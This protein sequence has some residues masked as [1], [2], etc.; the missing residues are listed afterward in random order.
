MSAGR[1]RSERGSALLITVLTSAALTALG[2]GYLLLA[3]TEQLISTSGRNTEQLL[4][5]AEAGARMIKTWFDNPVT[6]NPSIS[7]QVMHRFLGTY[8]LRNPAFYDR[9]RRIFDH[10]GDPNTAPVTAD[11][12]ASRPFYRQGRTLWA[13]SPYLD[14]FHKPYRGDAATTFL[15]SATGPD[16]ILEDRPNVIDLLD[17]L[18]NALF[19]DQERSGRISRI[20]I[21]AP[22]TMSFSGQPRSTGFATVEVTA[23]KFRR[24]GK[25]GIVPLVMNHSQKVAEATVKIVLG[26]VPGTLADGP[27]VSCGNISVGG[28]LHARWGRVIATGDVTLPAGLDAAVGSAFP[29]DGSDRRIHGN[30]PGD[31]YYDWINDPN[32]VVEDPWVT[33]EAAGDLTGY[34]GLPAQP[35][36]YDQ[37]APIDTDHSNLFQGSPSAT[38]PEIGYQ[39]LRAAA[40]SGEEHARYFEWDAST[41]LFKE[42]GRGA[43][44]TVRDWTHNQEGL[45]FFDTRDALPP[46]GH[47]PG[48]PQTNLTP[49][50]VIE[51]TDWAFSGLLYLNA[52]LFRMR[53]GSGA[54][55]VIIPPGEPYDDADG[56]GLHDPGEDYV[57]LL[58]PTTVIQGNPGSQIIKDPLASQTGTVTS[59][60][61]EL[62]SYATSASRDP[63]GVPISGEV[64]LF[65]VLFNA[66]NI[67]A[68]GPA[69]H[70]GSLVAGGDVIQSVA[71]SDTPEILFDQ[72]LNDGTWP[73]AEISFPR[74]HVILWAGPS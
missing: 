61:L 22:P 48:D 39:T 5:T 27:L 56:D 32:N 12:S 13:P 58:Y 2:L 14:L 70:F 60:D 4:H 55:R 30:I 33:V 53:S 36:P 73:P 67:D 3:D 63:Q 45:F 25:L 26:E 16:L 54:V 1:R 69:R 28:T 43:G 57:N 10:D 41:G 66:G 23:T 11:G 59:P 64:N 17:V 40:R 38:C 44:R 65:G 21:Y 72:R 7:T 42:W 9:S 6:G 31:D 62:Y 29:W 49:P 74:T 46:N 20:A 68:L 47:G 15:G 37:N 52:E 8:D 34:G 35:F 18:N 71:G 19:T 50:V 24:L 51:G